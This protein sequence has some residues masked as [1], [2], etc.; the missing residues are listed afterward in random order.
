VPR[1]LPAHT[2]DTAPS[3]RIGVPSTYAARRGRA[4]TAYP[5]VNAVR[6]KAVGAGGK[7]VDETYPA[8]ARLVLGQNRKCCLARGL[9]AIISSNSGFIS[10]SRIAARRNVSLFCLSDEDRTRIRRVEKAAATAGV[11]KEERTGVV[12]TCYSFY[13]AISAIYCV[14]SSAPV[15]YLMA[16]VQNQATLTKGVRTG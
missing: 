4:E 2:V 11:K 15:L 6:Q 8:A 3:A 16:W 7:T 14:Y 13:L 12:A 9:G 5:C 1:L 10:T